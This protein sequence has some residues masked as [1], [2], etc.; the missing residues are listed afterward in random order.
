MSGSTEFQPA[1]TS[2]FDGSAVRRRFVVLEHDHPFLHWDFFIE[3]EDALAAWRLL[4]SPRAG[5][6]IAAV[7]LPDHRR[8]YLDY[9]GPV[10]GDRGSVHRIHSGTLQ[11]SRTDEEWL[12][13][14]LD[15]ELAQRCRLIRTSSDQLWWEF[16]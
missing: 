6:R 3:Q 2:E 1:A 14:V 16:E 15:S 4:E 12:Y 5:V 13:T 9:E 8:H 10:S 7:P 11:K